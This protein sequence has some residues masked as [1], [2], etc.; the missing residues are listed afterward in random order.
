MTD[1]PS[2]RWRRYLRFFGPNVKADVQD[3][4]QFHMEMRIRDYESRGMTR[5]EAERAARERFGNVDGVERQL[6]QHDASHTRRATKREWM[7]D[8]V[9]DAR[10]GVRGFRRTPGFFVTAILILGIGIGA[11]VA[12]FTVFRTVLVRKLPVRDQDRVVVMWT[13]RTPESDFA[14]W[15]AVLAPFRKQSRTLSEFAGV[16][17]WGATTAP[18]TV[19]D[20]T[21][22]MKQGMVT[23]NFFDVLGARPFVG[24]F[25]HRDD[26]EAGFAPLGKDDANASR[27]VV[28]SYDAWHRQFGGDA[29]VVGKRVVD[30]AF[31]W[32]YTIVGVAPPGL[33]YPAGVDFWIPMRGGWKAGTSV[34]VIGRLAPGA[35]IAAARS[36]YVA[37]TQQADSGFKIKG[38]HAETF[39]ETVVGN[40]RP[41]LDVLTA[42]VALLLVI[43]CLNVGNLL[44]FRASGRTREFAV[45]RALG[46]QFGDIVRQLVVESALLALA[47][48]VLGLFIATVLIRNVGS[49]AP[50]NLPRLDEIRIVNAPIL[51][52]IGITALAVL[53]FGVL[54]TLLIA[55]G[56]V[57]SSLRVGVRTGV[58]SRKRRF[59]RQS[60][61]ASQVAL[62]LVMIAGAALLARSLVRLQGG[63][64][65][66]EREHVMGVSFTPDWIRD[67]S[68]QSLV[69]VA[70]R[71]ERRFASI[72]GV[73]AS[74]PLVVPPMVG[75]GVW[76]L[77]FDK[78]GQSADDAENNPTT[79]GD[80][81]GP[82]FFQTFGI[83]I[84]RGR[85]FSAT[86]NASAP[87]VMVVSESFARLYW[88]NED[89]IGKQLRMP[90][91][92][93]SAVGGDGWRTVVGIARDAHLRVLRE[94]T[95]MSYI[96][97]GQG[98]WQGY[99]AIR[100]TQSPAALA[101]ALRV[102]VDEVAP[103]TRL[104]D[105]R[106]MDDILAPSLAEPRLGTLLMSSFGLVALLLAAIGLYGVMASLVRDQT[107]DIGIRIALGASV[108]RVRRDVL[109]RAAIVVGSGA[110]VGLITA[111][112]SSR[113]LSSLLFG[114]SPTDP[115]ALGGAPCALLLVIGAL[116]AYL[117]ARRATRIDPVQALRAD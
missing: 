28:L 24:D 104:Y 7:N 58:E 112:A 111:I 16:A 68:A 15:P 35:S 87:L 108:G 97:I 41:V 50:H 70:Q 98:T 81:V 57:A 18:L 92:G 55:G 13:Y 43:V 59:V 23:A 31:K 34:F 56:D 19:G 10:L 109:R 6:T 106:S 60:L 72:P 5:A 100:A 84:V 90:Q 47:G 116:A 95:P 66:F 37:F 1:T 76:Q 45:R 8:L 91:A 110:L 61:V 36:E 40:V 71:L 78:F 69:D 21:F 39:T 80:V 44:L 114:V 88:P 27:K 25:F 26:E 99:F 83:P 94:T 73:I 12:M 51:P 96:P 22:A 93:S 62:A 82:G 85:A 2:P 101:S 79:P 86:D 64:I 49:I 32:T 29:A 53:V 105:V 103:T 3:E 17:H 107:R 115:L 42:A 117:P 48:G 102:A 113:V 52:A 38:A 4:V 89:A 63:D 33:A 54:P 74:T 75:T 77:R 30:P 20:R 9:R 67:T 65:G 46:A 14:A 11:S